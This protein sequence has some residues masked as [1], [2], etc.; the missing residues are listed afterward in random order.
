[1]KLA[2]YFDIQKL[3]QKNVE[4][5]TALRAFGLAHRAILDDP[6]ALLRA[7][8]K[9]RVERDS[10]GSTPGERYARPISE[11]AFWSNAIAFGFGVTAAFA[12]LHYNGKE[13]VNLLY[14]LFAAVLL[15]LL[16]MVGSIVAMLRTKRADNATVHFSPAYWLQKLLGFVH[17][18][19][20]NETSAYCIDP[21][22]VDWMM[23]RR[24]QAMGVS[25]G[26]G[27]LAGLLVTIA[28]HDVAFVWSTTLS[29][30]PEA[31]ARFVKILAWP[32]R[33]WLPQ[34]VPSA[35]LIAQSRY[36]RLG[37]RID[38]TMVANAARLGAW[39]PFLAMATAVYT[40]GLRLVLWGI[41]YIGYTRALRKA[42]LRLEGVETI[43]EAMREPTVRT[44]AEE[45][46]DKR[47]DVDTV[48]TVSPRSDT[49]LKPSYDT[50]VGWAC[51]AEK[52]PA[53]AE[54]IG[55]TSQHYLTI[56]G[57]KTHEEK[58][59]TLHKISGETLF[60]VKGW[61]P[62]IAEFADIL[63]S[64]TEYASRIVVVP[65]GLPPD[66]GMADEKWLG[67]WRRWLQAHP[68]NKTEVV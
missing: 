18:Q 33:D 21:T 47:A 53:V 22:V 49:A 64:A 60:V 48:T 51:E 55:V 63:E 68:I 35:D 11:I 66:Y 37:G 15:P 7:W 27:V 12:L 42:T 46:G 57:S 10:G 59:A 31:F 23:I 34:A 6:F 9:K 19:R 3:A 61:E 13:P 16:T 50:I 41:S 4:D 26:I 65:V 30:D 20:R 44:T 56:E 36:F 43:L 24:A 39:W 28:L 58:I 45:H 2:E 8:A 1:M 25:Y 54:S 29:V 40:I 52:L 38:P 32:W 67:V 5:K 17:R 14:Y 62:P